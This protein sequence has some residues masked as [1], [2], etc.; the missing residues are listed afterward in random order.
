LVY[1]VLKWAFVVGGEMVAAIRAM[2]GGRSEIDRVSVAID[3]ETGPAE[4][5]FQAE[6]AIKP[7]LGA[8]GA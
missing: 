1:P 8:G 5:C 2:A 4:M 6:G 7:G 3:Q